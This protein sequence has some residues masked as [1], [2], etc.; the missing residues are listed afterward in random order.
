MIGT[1][2]HH[3]TTSPLMG[4]RRQMTPTGSLIACRLQF[5][6]EEPGPVLV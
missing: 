5:I 3:N 2:T 1:D 6:Q 4:G